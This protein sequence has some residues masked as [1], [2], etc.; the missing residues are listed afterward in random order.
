MENEQIIN[1]L[2]IDDKHEELTSTKGR[3]K[4]NGI[5]L[6]PFK[7]SKAG[8]K[9][10]RN[11]LDF[12]DGVLLDARCFENE[13]DT[14]GTEDTQYSIDALREIN[15]LDKKFEIFVF[16]GQSEEFIDG[17][18][19]KL[20]KKV[21]EKGNNDHVVELMERLKE[22]AKNL[23]D[24]QL[25]I[26]YA[27]VFQLT[28][29]GIL[30]AQSNTRLLNLVKFL[31]GEINLDVNEL[32]PLRKIIENLFTYLSEVKLIP[33][34]IA[35][36]RGALNKSSRFLAGINDKYVFSDELIPALIAENLHR[37]LN[38]TQDGAHGS[39]ALNL[40]VDEYLAS[41]NN[42]YLFKSCIYLLFDI[43]S[44]VGENIS[45]LNDVEINF[46]K[47]ERKEAHGDEIPGMVIMTENG[48]GTFLSHTEQTRCSIPPPL[49]NQYGLIQGQELVVVTKPDPKDS[50][51]IHIEK[52]IKL[53]SQEN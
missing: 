49:V 45:L 53:C 30:S 20:F 15:E 46:A 14:E 29:A 43:L 6:H 10:L 28:N 7:S 44:W 17:S 25:K 5:N 3:A 35:N 9:E 48:Y 1:I 4:F 21:Y 19:R 32:T 40:K 42:N 31:E 13:D 16:T 24:N 33:E 2:W 11:N 41:T 18:Y 39:G 47:W 23:P 8:L 51:N 36:E 52:I 50:N 27:P 37:L 26:K 12:Y 22:C 38:I 34:E